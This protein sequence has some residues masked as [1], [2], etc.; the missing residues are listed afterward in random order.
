MMSIKVST[1]DR[2]APS[3]K[4]L[5]KGNTKSKFKA[6]Y[7][8]QGEN[9]E[10]I[11]PQLLENNQNLEN[12]LEDIK[13]ELKTEEKKTINNL[14]SLNKELEELNKVQINVCNKNKSLL[15]RL[16]EMEKEINK[17]FDEKFKVSK[18]LEKQKSSLYKR[19]I[20][21]EIKSKENE[22]NNV[23][24]DI[25]Y[26]Q[27]EI[28]RL[29]KILEENNEKEGNKLE[30]NYNELKKNIEKVQKEVNDLNQIK[31]AHKF[32]YT[33]TT[34]LK[35]KLNVLFNDIEFER[36]RGI[37]FSYGQ[38]KKEMNTVNQD[39]KRNIYGTKVRKHIL[40]NIV[41]KHDLK[42][43]QFVSQKSYDFLKNQMVED[44]KGKLNNSYD[45]INKGNLEEEKVENNN[46]KNKDN[47]KVYLFTEAE[48]ELF[49][50]IVPNE[51]F[52]NLNDKF[53]QKE[54]EMKEIEE[55]CKEPKELKRK[56]YL[57]NLK[58]EEITVKTKELRIKKANLMAENTK[59][60]KKIFEIKN[61]IKMKQRE[62]DK[63][64]K[65]IIRFTEKNNSLNEVI[66]KYIAERKKQ[67]EEIKEKNN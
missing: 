64:N 11:L 21:I 19:N 56:L 23:Q 26:N 8:S 37:M 24:K 16:K 34:I 35:S 36:K 17:K 61:R 54:S 58:Y 13:I 25:K 20:D 40:K 57:D 41:N 42:D 31:F 60:N 46:N 9:A 28:N 50:K 15:S 38:P 51:L 27:K 47:I 63:E 29:N 4:E 45:K 3:N 59:N 48:K 43:V 14:D 12:E 39:N 22:K 33:N 5:N 10:M 53:N 30:E 1:E 66:K 2:D 6:K 44:G 65:K 52:N 55:T 67:K 7:P 49:K 32:C 62:I 18:V